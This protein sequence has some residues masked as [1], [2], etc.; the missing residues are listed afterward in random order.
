MSRIKKEND[1]R[2]ALIILTENGDELAR[3]VPDPIE[4][5]LITG[6]ANLEEQKI[7]QLQE[8]AD[9]ILSLIDV[10]GVD[11]APLD[12]GQGETAIKIN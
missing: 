9:L 12:L 11:E 4:L 5:K 7:H 6:L 8:A 10:Q 3:T 2:V 1:R